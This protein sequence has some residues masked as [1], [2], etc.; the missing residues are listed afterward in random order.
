MFP[1]E[2][3]SGILNPYFVSV[4]ASE[5]ARNFLLVELYILIGIA[6]V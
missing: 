3:S 5:L 2:F 6:E 1:I 4:S